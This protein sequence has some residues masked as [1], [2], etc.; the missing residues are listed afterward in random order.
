MLIV[1][2]ASQEKA[3]K[4][5]Q[6]ITALDVISQSKVN[7]IMKDNKVCTFEKTN[8][9]PITKVVEFEGIVDG[10]LRLGEQEQKKLNENGY[11][12]CY[13]SSSPKEKM[14]LETQVSLGIARTIEVWKDKN[15][16]ISW[17]DNL[18]GNTTPLNSDEVKV[19]Q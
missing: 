6:T 3:L 9:A 8:K 19:I 10:V 4:E 12:K 15:G 7:L 14:S 11:V 17:K 18:S 13:R 1:L 5:G 16:E 2:L